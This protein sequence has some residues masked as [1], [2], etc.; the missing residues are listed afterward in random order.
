MGDTPIDFDPRTSAAR[1]PDTAANEVPEHEFESQAAMQLRRGSPWLRFRGPL[2]AEFRAAAFIQIGGNRSSNQIAFRGRI[3]LG[4]IQQS[5]RNSI[6]LH[7]EEPLP[8]V[9]QWARVKRN[10]SLTKAG[11]Q[12]LF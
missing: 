1:S 11:K 10:A 5:R 2:E 4:P 6:V 8:I 3:G 9:S 7:K 12:F